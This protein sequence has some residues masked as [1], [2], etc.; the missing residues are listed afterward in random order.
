[1]RTE[2]GRAM[3]TLPALPTISAEDIEQALTIRDLSKLPPAVRVRYY[4]ALCASVDV[5]PLGYPFI[6]MKNQAGEL[7]FYATRELGDQLRVKHRVNT[8]ILAREREG[9]LYIVTV[10][11]RLPNGRTEEEQGVVDISGLKGQ[12]LG[13]AMM[14]ASTKAKRRATLALCGLG[15]PSA[16]EGEAHPI[17]MDWQTGELLEDAPRPSI[18]DE[19]KSL[20]EHLA[21]VCGDPPEPPRSPQNAPGSFQGPETLTRPPEGK[22]GDTV[23][24]KPPSLTL[25]PDAVAPRG[26][27]AGT[28][29]L[30]LD[31]VLAIHRAHGKD[32]AWVA[33]FS[34]RVLREAG[35]DT[36]TAVP[37]SR[38]VQLLG[39]TRRYYQERTPL[40]PDA[41]AWGTDLLALAAPL[42][43]LALYEE[44][45]EQVTETALSPDVVAALERR[46]RAAL[47]QQRAD[48]APEAGDGG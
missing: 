29:S 5:S 12:A 17:R 48:A 38:L 45:E 6:A 20:P 18:A 2:T 33:H 43:D 23:T 1:M 15:V 27:G 24:Q 11:A 25:T 19:G 3:R 44:V 21:D 28:G 30:Y 31:Q 40:P 4:L 37:A 26:A 46:I 32:P 9:D 47:A 8:R 10:E 36:V 13:N 39:D 42:T 35:V 7:F 14:K 34:R 41:P 16:E 22:D